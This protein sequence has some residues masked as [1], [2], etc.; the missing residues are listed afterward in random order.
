MVPCAYC[1]QPL[2]LAA[3]TFDHIIPLSKGG[4]NKATNGAIACAPCNSEKGSMSVEE[5]L[6]FR[7]ARDRGESLVRS[8]GDPNGIPRATK[9]VV[10]IMQGEQCEAE[11][12]DNYSQSA[13]E[14]VKREMRK[15]LGADYLVVIERRGLED[16]KHESN[17]A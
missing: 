7:A 3:A 16:R 14:Q 5:Y 4:Y 15:T 2:S 10:R 13:A 11:F 1:A 12:D 6:A 17:Y 9:F 8:A